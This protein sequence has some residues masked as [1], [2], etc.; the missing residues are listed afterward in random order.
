MTAREFVER[1]PSDIEAIVKE[2]LQRVGLKPTSKGQVSLLTRL[3]FSG[4]SNYFFLNPD[5]IVKMGYIEFIKN[6]DKDQM[7][8]LNIIRNSKEGVV[9]A[10]TLWRYYKGE[11]AT[12]AELKG[13]IDTFV[14]DL[15]Q[16][17]QT[18]E[19]EITKLTNK[20]Q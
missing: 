16:Y 7:F 6:P 19:F 13:V 4:I 8:A 3:I 5:N 17:S 10:H 18:Q 12:E 1:K 20:L 9:N 15:L 11:L 14:H 2:C